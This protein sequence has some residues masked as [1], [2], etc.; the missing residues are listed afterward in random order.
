MNVQKS[1]RLAHTSSVFISVIINGL[2][3]LAL[4]TFITISDGMQEDTSTVKVIDPSEQEDIVEVEPEIEPEEVDPRELDD[5]LDFT[6]DTPMETDF[7]QETEVVETP[8]EA[9][10]SSLSDLMSD[11]SSP[12][13]MTGLLQGRTSTA[14]KAAAAKYGRGLE[15]FS[16]PA[17]MKAL[18]WL[19]DHQHQNGSWTEEGETSGR[20]FNAGYTGLALLTFLAH[21][22]TPSSAEFGPTVAK[23]IRFL[24]ENQGSD[25]LFK[26][27]GAHGSYGHAMATYALA[28]AYTMTGN[29]LLREPLQRGV[30]V[31]IKGQQP[32]GGFDYDYKLSNRNDL[33][34]VGWNLQALKAASIAGID[35]AKVPEH[36]QRA[37][38]GMLIGSREKD[39]ARTF[40]YKVMNSKELDGPNATVSAAGTLALHLSGRYKSREAKE[41]IHYLERFIESDTLPVW[42]EGDDSSGDINFWYYTVQAFFHENPEGRNFRRYMPAMV[43]ALA[44]NQAPDGHWLLPTEKGR[45]RGK[46]FNTTLAALGLMVYYRYLPSTQAENIKQPSGQ[47]AP[48]E[49]NPDEIGF[50]I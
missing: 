38:D 33:S 2:L 36:L 48:V 43:K 6:L 40:V 10:V 14:R 17:V 49:E 27:A 23:A 1:I 31:I 22:E 46:V 42:S 9:D 35:N 21:G 25:G 13:V 8:T 44:Q 19:R 24:V 11:V 45:N 12:V 29:P 26:P 32:D 37:M 34:V 50:E 5:L 39:G 4:F 20:G 7:V 15:R 28:E 41:A 47:P 16:E 30:T 18:E 3:I